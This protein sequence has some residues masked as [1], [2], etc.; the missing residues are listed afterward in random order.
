M[1]IKSLE[2]EIR[3]ILLVRSSKLCSQTCNVYVAGSYFESCGGRS[4][5]PRPPPLL[6]LFFSHSLTPQQNRGSS[7]RDFESGR[8]SVCIATSTEQQLGTDK[9]NLKVRQTYC[10]VNPSELLFEHFLLSL[11]IVFTGK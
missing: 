4:P 5:S 6:S 2:I 1:A 7:F 11:S 10:E 3:L 8:A 9:F